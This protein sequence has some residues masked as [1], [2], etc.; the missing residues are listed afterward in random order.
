MMY[1]DFAY[2]Y[3]K[4]MYDLDYEKIYK[5]IKEVLGKKSLEPM[6]VLEMACGT[7]ALTEKITRD[8]KVHAFDLSEDMLSVCENKI[9]NKNLKLFKQNMAGFSAPSNYDAIFSVGDSLNYVTDEKDFESA[10]KSSY[11]HLNEDGIF[12]FDLNTEYKFK[13][14][15]PVTVDEVDDVLYIWENIYD[16][17]KKLN[18]YGVNFFRNIKDND[19]KRFY[20]E[21]FERAYDLSFV[22]NLLEEIGFCE[23]EVYDDYEFKDVKETTS[24]YTIIARR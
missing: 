20:E 16:D 19:Y 1:E 9:R 14:I 24:R 7:G 18:T 13:N 3:D 6:L 11:Q 10:L 12:I 8:Y 22:K 17:G 2:F 4:L 23:I 21:H 5:F 15:P